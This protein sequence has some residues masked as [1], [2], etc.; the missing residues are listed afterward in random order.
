MRPKRTTTQIKQ[1]VNALRMLFSMGLLIPA[2]RSA[3]QV[4]LAFTNT[5]GHRIEALTFA[6]MDLGV[7]APDSTRTFP[8]DSVLL[9]GPIP[10]AKATGSIPGLRMDPDP[11]E[12]C[13]TRARYLR[14]GMLGAC[15]R[16]TD[17]FGGGRE[18][19]LAPCP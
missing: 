10:C 2:M 14:E 15:I 4:E 9:C 18:L 12:H 19:R 3:G 17:E 16:L 1:P 5:T 6:G 11:P 13:V 7:L 8:M